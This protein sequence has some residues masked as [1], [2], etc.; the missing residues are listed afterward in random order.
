MRE[1]L[2]DVLAYAFKS[3]SSSMHFCLP[4]Q[5][6]TYDPSLKKASVKPLI[7]RK[8]VDKTYLELQVIE[9]VPVSFYSTST[10][11][12]HVPL[13]RG[14]GCTIFFS[15]RSMTEYLSLGGDSEP[16][17]IRRFSLTDGICFPGLFPFASPGK[18]P[19]GNNFEILYNDASIKID[20]SG[21]V[22]INDNLEIII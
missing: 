16:S 11:I 9:D 14:D 18:L 22:T 8:L 6:E 21:T 4:G 20:D 7:K 2:S 13:V 12:F 10:A 3:L 5:I 17:D 19:S 1:E 15:E